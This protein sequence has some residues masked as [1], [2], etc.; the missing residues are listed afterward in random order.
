MDITVLIVFF[1]ILLLLLF[2]SVKIVPQQESWV[3]ERLGKFNRL[4]NPGLSFIIPF[5]D[6]VAYKHSLKEQVLDV[7]SQSAISNDNVSLKI[8]GVLYIKIMD[9]AAASYGV[10]N[11]YYAV[12][13]LA[14]TTM[15]SEIGKL[16]LEKTFEERD[17][18]NANIVFAINSAA[19]DWGVICMRHEIKD[20]QPPENVLQAMELLIAADRQKRAS[21]LESEGKR[22]AKINNAEA[23]KIQQVL[24][25]EGNYTKKINNAKADYESLVMASEGTAKGINLV[26]ASL[27]STNGMDA[28]MVKLAE[29]YL[30]Q[31]GHLAKS[32][33]TMI[34]PSNV[35]DVSSV[36]ASALNIYKNI[37]G[38]TKSK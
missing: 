17:T 37:S 28:V 34:I 22:Q 21:I 16:T 20:I 10:S 1:V 23:D 8:D 11:P 9:P 26:A 36:L 15:R 14:Q 4:L 12:I 29:N 30:Q 19:K 24:E 7:N 38:E 3:L 18:L 27:S 35:S 31:F 32:N 25:S 6:V 33:N 5:V 2:L 13:Q